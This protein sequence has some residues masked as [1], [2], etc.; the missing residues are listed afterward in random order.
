[1]AKRIEIVVVCLFM[2]IAMQANGQQYLRLKGYY[3]VYQSTN[4]MLSYFVDGMMELYV[5]LDTTSKKQTFVDRKFLGERRRKA[6]QANGDETF[7]RMNM[8]ALESIPLIESIKS[9]EYSTRNNGDV[10]RWADKCGTISKHK[11]PNQKIATTG[12]TIN[13]DNLMGQE[14]HEIEM[15]QLKMYGIIAR[16]TQF[17]EQET[18]VEHAGT[19]TLK[20][21]YSA[22]KHQTFMAHYRGED[23]DE[24]IDVWSDLFITD[25]AIISESE[26]KKI[27]K[28]KPRT[29]TFEIPS[30]VPQLDDDILQA[31]LQ[32]VEY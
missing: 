20:D 29:L 7:V 30:S 18:Y 22:R 12:I 23:T 5:P 28:E 14:N 17:D 10:Y 21:L 19:Y 25:R 4:F 2:A 27:K 13:M 9:E 1:M 8:P 15:N 3:R 24:Q 32:M 6:K 11:F 16:M 31:W 26:M